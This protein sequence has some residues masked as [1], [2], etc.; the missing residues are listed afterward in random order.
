MN[1]TVAR[2]AV[3]VLLGVALVALG[4]APM[5]GGEAR[6]STATAAEPGAVATAPA[7]SCADCHI[8]NVE[9]MPAPEHFRECEMSAHGKASVGCE[10][11]HGGD[12]TTYDAFR[13]HRGM[14]RPS[15]PD[16]PVG[17]GNLA[18]TCGRC[19]AG[20]Y[21]AYQRGPHYALL[22]AGRRDVPG[23]DDCHGSVAAHLLSP[24]ALEAQCNSCH[25][26]GA[27]HPLP[28]VGEQARLLL[29]GID[30]V[31]GLLNQAKTMIDRVRDPARRED[32]REQ[33]RQ[34]EVPLIEATAVGHAVGA[35]EVTERLDTAQLRAEALLQRLANPE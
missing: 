31:R 16:S 9:T 28:E 3:G 19:H 15:D 7:S 29:S 27:E 35:L 4:A 34:A 32:Y 2:E 20:P 18:A 21:V 8:A 5:A 23:C 13:A 24:R 22:Q 6:P 26:A 30:H 10:A 17:P 11:C 14:L 33:W 1:R 12:A 25:A